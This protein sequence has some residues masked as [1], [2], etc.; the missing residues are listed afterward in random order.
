M[1]FFIQIHRE[2]VFKQKRIINKDSEFKNRPN[3]QVQT[4]TQQIQANFSKI[5]QLSQFKYQNQNDKKNQ[6]SFRKIME[7]Q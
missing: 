7:I 1:N 2:D 4:F 5:P 3:N 6:L